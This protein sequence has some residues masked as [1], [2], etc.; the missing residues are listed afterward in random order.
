MYEKF[1]GFKERPF[2]LVP[3]P[4]YLFLSKSHEDAL[5][6]LT[7]AVSQGDG[8]VAITGEVGTGKT[9]LCRVFL[10]NLEEQ[11]E[12]AYIFN[13]MLDAV[14]LLKAVNDEFGI[15]AQADNTKDLIDTLNKFL[16]KKKS[17]G[18]KVILLIDEAQN[19][20]KDVLEQLRL[21]S[22]LET[23]TSKLIQIILVGQPELRDILDSHELRQLSQRITLSCH[24]TP[25]NF[26][27]TREYI[28]HRIRIASQKSGIKF[29]S[30][31]FKSIYKYSGGIPR[32][33]NIACD[34][35]ILTAYG[36]NQHKITGSITRA[37]VRELRL[38]KDGKTTSR[39]EKKDI[40]AVSGICLF[41][42]LIF[43]YINGIPN[44]TKILQKSDNNIPEP[45]PLN[46]I[47]SSE[48]KPEITEPELEKI[49]YEEKQPFVTEEQKDNPSLESMS[50]NNYLTTQDI[51][52]SRHQALK[53]A[54]NLWQTDIA[55]MEYLTSIEDTQ[56]FFSVAAGQNTMS[57]LYTNEGL[58]LIR[59]LDLPAIIELT[60]QE[61]EP[62]YLTIG[63]LNDNEIILITDQYQI[64]TTYEDIKPYWSG[65]AYIPWK[66]FS[67]LTGIIPRNSDDDNIIKLKILL[68]DI[69][70]KNI[71]ISPDY[72]NETQAAI[73][74]IQ[75]KNNI[76]ID[77][78]VGPITKIIIYNEKKSFNIP[79]ISSSKLP[80]LTREAVN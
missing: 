4:A 66:N 3:N 72:D 19:L 10:E 24:I 39:F 21:L 15:N 41:L 11:T 23:T 43:F 14:Q 17:Q 26:K 25:L 76:I 7:Y 37:S 20:G 56:T 44:I 55:V 34:R 58:D 45:K 78:K 52:S 65:T 33:T 48:E 63:S 54:I 69:G 2:Q 60:F 42:I 70:F 57:I 35:A 67:G 51:S 68:Q 1:F 61:I 27:E 36:L 18:K 32:L 30:S 6:H 9:T 73:E 74:A 12:A 59:K 13:P 46:I 29:S 77:G 71:K 5:A 8:F 50:L 79:H 38:R 80:L 47:V 22:N 62:V 31:A 49:P 75:K 16:M 40:L 28:Q 53:T 64:N